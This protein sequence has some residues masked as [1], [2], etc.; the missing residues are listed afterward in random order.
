M[1]QKL[2]AMVVLAALVDALPRTAQSQMW[3]PA[4]GGGPAF[5]MG[6]LKDS[7]TETGWLGFAGLDYTLAAMP[8]ATVGVSLSYAH[9]PYE[10]TADDATNIPAATVDV[11]YAFGAATGAKIQPYVRAGIGVL[12][13]KYDAGSSTGG[14]ES[15][16]K[17]AGA[18]GVGISLNM[19]PVTPFV[20]VHYITG[21]SDTQYY[22]I[23]AGLAFPMSGMTSTMSRIRP[24]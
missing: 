11:A 13:H 17:L 10:G 7:G 6:D 8:G 3:I 15:E 4:V 18:A 1:K 14:D 21:G 16:T 12:Q 20:G 22:T 24:R 5:A 9:I 19:G 2:L 23:Y